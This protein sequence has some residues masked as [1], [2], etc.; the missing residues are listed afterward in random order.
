MKLAAFIGILALAPA[1]FNISPANARG[2]AVPLCGGDGSVRLVNLPIPGGELPG[3]DVP[4]C[5]AKA[6]H[7]GQRKKSLCCEID[8]EQ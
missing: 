5:C 2:M 8:A 3:K 7:T 4:G 1:A 6:C